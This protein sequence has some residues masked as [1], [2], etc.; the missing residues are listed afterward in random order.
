MHFVMTGTILEVYGILD[1]VGGGN[2]VFTMYSHD[3]HVTYIDKR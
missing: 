2:V 3:S 1:R